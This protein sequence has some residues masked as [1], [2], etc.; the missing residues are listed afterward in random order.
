[1]RG[2]TAAR[3]QLQ[4]NTTAADRHGRHTLTVLATDTAGNSLSGPFNPVS[5]S[6]TTAARTAFALKPRRA[7]YLVIWVTSMPPGG[8]AAAVNEVRVSAGG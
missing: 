6:K 3:Y 5:G 7:R 2:E 4:W 1:M 8:V